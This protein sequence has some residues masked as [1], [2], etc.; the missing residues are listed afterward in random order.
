MPF[1]VFQLAL[2][3]FVTVATDLSRWTNRDGKVPF[4]LNSPQNSRILALKIEFSRLIFF[5]ACYKGSGHAVR[6]FA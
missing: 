6:R 2:S 1:P 5:A 3:D 4:K